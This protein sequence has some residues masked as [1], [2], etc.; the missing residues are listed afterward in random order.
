MQTKQPLII[1]FIHV[2]QKFIFCWVCDKEFP[3]FCILGD[4]T[5]A[6]TVVDTNIWGTMV[7]DYNGKTREERQTWDLTKD[8]TKYV[9]R[10]REL[11]QLQ[12]LAMDG[13]GYH[14]ALELGQG[15]HTR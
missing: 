12:R 5:V 11:S 4:S 8:V 2:V 15:L 1:I 13:V 3:V 14:L 6:L 7:P 9:N 10:V